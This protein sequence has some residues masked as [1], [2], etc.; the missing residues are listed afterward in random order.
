[1]Q[2]CECVYASLIYTLL[3]P[4]ALL[5]ASCSSLKEALSNRECRLTADNPYDV[6]SVDLSAQSIE[7]I[8]KSDRGE[9]LLT[10]GKVNAML[11]AAGDS[12][13]AITN[14]GIFTKAYAPLGL[15]VE[16]YR[17]QVPLN[18]GDGY[19]NFYL[20]PNGV[21]M[22]T[23]DR[24]QIVTATQ[25]DT[26]GSLPRH[27]LQSGPLLLQGGLI[28]PA[29]VPHSTNCRLRTGIGVDRRGRVHIVLSN[30]A[31][32]L[33]SFANYFRQVLGCD[34]ALYLDGSISTLYAPS[35]GRHAQGKRKYATFLV[36][37]ARGPE[38]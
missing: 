11:A 17:Q 13:I 7:L 12:V 30:G 2:V 8:W 31:V 37:I 38:T 32:N 21:F 28:H 16:E 26:T 9:P 27:A 10:V 6:V 36:V 20:K 5:L 4:A 14:G 34:D 19:G 22:V 24:A 18:T 29:F 35:L 25:Y 1:M 33:Y 15:Y 3:L 23:D